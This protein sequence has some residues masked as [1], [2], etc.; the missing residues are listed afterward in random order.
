LIAAATI[1]AEAEYEDKGNVTIVEK[2]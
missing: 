2:F 1:K